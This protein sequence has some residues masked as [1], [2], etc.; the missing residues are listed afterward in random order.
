M[1]NGWTP[2]RRA[3]QAAMIQR[4]KPWQRSTGPK[5]DE[6]KA[7]VS[8]NADQGGMRFLLRSMARDLREQ[9]KTHRELA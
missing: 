7:V 9:Q 3:R 6:G 1:S 4:W 2:E 5:R 8:R